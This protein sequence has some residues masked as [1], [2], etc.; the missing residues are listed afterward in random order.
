MNGLEERRL[1]TVQGRPSFVSRFGK[2]GLNLELR[3]RPKPAFLVVI[4]GM[5]EILKNTDLLNAY[6]R[7]SGIATG[8]LTEDQNDQDWNGN[9]RQP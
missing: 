1:V 9:H 8:V 4:T 3:L 2:M 5:P 7:V 6:V